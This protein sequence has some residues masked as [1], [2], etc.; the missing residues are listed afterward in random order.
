MM[1]LKL[2]S[3]SSSPG[4]LQDDG[5][6]AVEQLPFIEAVA[7]RAAADDVD[8]LVE[9]V[10]HHV[11]LRRAAGARASRLPDRLAG[12]LD[13]GG[14]ER[15]EVRLLAVRGDRHVRRRD[16]ETERNVASRRRL[17]DS[18]SQPAAEQVEVALVAIELEIGGDRRAVDVDEALRFAR[19]IARRPNLDH[20]RNDGLKRG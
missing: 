15:L 20:E 4:S 5:P 12:G 11:L 8:H 17:G 7:L 10:E 3:L 1:L 16:V 14:D 6:H 13:D 2:P 18:V 19:D 9:V